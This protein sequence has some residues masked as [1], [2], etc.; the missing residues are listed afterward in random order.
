MTTNRRDFLKGLAALPLLPV[1]VRSEYQAR[2]DEEIVE[3]QTVG[4]DIAPG[5][6]KLNGPYQME[7]EVDRQIP[8]SA[9]TLTYTAHGSAESTLII[10]AELRDQYGN[11]VKRL[12]YK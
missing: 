3:D 1:V 10:T 7:A 8:V 12:G 6:W 9:R 4:V 11:I 2:A 5:V